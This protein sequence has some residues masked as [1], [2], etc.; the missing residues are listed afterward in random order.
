MTQD[1][2][3]KEEKF[4]ES[5]TE[6]RERL[7]D[8]LALDI[9][10]DVGVRD[11]TIL[12]KQIGIYYVTGLTDNEYLIEILKELMD[13]D[14]RGRKTSDVHKAIENHLTHV[15][16][17]QT[18]SMDDA[19]TQ[20]L[21]GLVFVLLEGST[22]VFVV[23]VRNY[24]GRGPEEP[25]TERVV[26]GARDG[27]T[28]N[29]IMNTG[30]TRRRIRDERLRHEI[31]QVGVRS[32]TDI[33]VSYI[34]GIADPDLVNIVKKELKAINIDGI[35][36]ADKVVEEY[37]VKQGYNPF[38]LVRYTERP[39]VA[40]THLLEGHI[41]LIVDT[42]PSVIITP[43][44][45]FHHVQHAEEYRQSAAVG[46]FLRFMRF[47]GIMFSLFILPF[48]LL[49]ATNQDLLP[50]SLEFIGPEETKHIPIVLQIVFGEM[51]IELLRMAAIHT[52]SPLATALGLVAALLI[53]DMAVQV[54]YLTPE[55][56][57]YVSLGAIGMFATPSYELGVALRMVRYLFLF[58]VA[59]F[60]VPGL[61]IA[62]LV[63]VLFLCS[64]KPFNKPYLWPFLPFSPPE[65]WQILIRA[66]VPSLKW[67]PS[68]VNPQDKI[69]QKE[70]NSQ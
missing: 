60:K 27:Y 24:P 55:V 12:G 18:D 16:V 37:I 26:R 54:G 32:K 61:V 20:M 3:K 67:R 1:Y 14:A 70:E 23:D 11:L 33:C 35:T 68:I 48:W 4:S 64:T 44:T 58:S 25:D 36:M 28:E 38:P 10:F 13:L 29:I 49:L 62:F 43:T 47:T 46:S 22:N 66:T 41:V 56:I 8:R 5:Y 34:E 31:L 59:F 21:S 30:L 2:K 52:P 45:L 40:A 17:E 50:Q 7:K 69:R 63:F 19:I 53:G 9:S 51:G 15:Q 6:N 39:D 42:T 65:M 57:L